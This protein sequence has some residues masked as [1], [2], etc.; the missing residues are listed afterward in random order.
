MLAYIDPQTG[1]FLWCCPLCWESIRC[2]DQSE[3][4]QLEEEAAC[5]GCRARELFES[6]PEM[7][8]FAVDMWARTDSWPQ[9]STWMEAIPPSGISVLGVDYHA[10]DLRYPRRTAVLS[11]T[12]S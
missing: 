11:W 12:A 10:C 9:S 7:I 5:E 1:E 3:I 4:D 6:N 2:Q 8:G